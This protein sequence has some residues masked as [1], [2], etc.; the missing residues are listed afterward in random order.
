MQPTWFSALGF[1]VRS[2]RWLLCSLALVSFQ[3]Q[4]AEIIV[5]PGDNTLPGAIS[6]AAEGDT[7]L[8][9]EGTYF[10]FALTIDKSLNFKAQTNAS[11]IMTGKAGSSLFND[12]T[13][14]NALTEVDVSFTGIQLHALD[15][16]TLAGAEDVELII[17]EST[18]TG[19]DLIGDSSGNL[20][21]LVMMGN[22]IASPGFHDYTATDIVITGN[23]F[24]YP[25][26]G[27][28]YVRLNARDTAH[29]I[30]NEVTD[31]HARRTSLLW[32]N[33]GQNFVVANRFVDN[34]SAN[35]NN[36]LQDSHHT[37]LN[38]QGVSTRAIIK[39]NSFAVDFPSSF[40]PDP[41]DPIDNTQINRYRLLAVQSA[42]PRGVVLE[43]N[44]VDYG[45]DADDVRF[46]DES[47]VIFTNA[48]IIARN[49]IVANSSRPL[50]NL[51]TSEAEI[52]SILE[53]NLCDNGAAGG[54][55]DTDVIGSVNFVDNVNFAL[56]AGSAGINA[57][58]PLGL[59]N[60]VDGSQNDLGV[61]GGAFPI[62]Q[63]DVQRADGRIEPY[64][65]PLFE[66]NKNVSGDGKL[67]VRVIGLA[68]SK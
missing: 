60:D 63:Y 22:I 65:Y 38:I 58:N 6:L 7:L 21:L 13:I 33:S 3:S 50:I 25:T 53:Y 4:A 14:G 23:R 35:T 46:G 62:D 34:N 42:L 31:N 56:G 18:I 48:A 67:N 16:R 12:V 28:G 52:F 41:T 2:P 61:Y 30:G 40:E 32:L 45:M 54:V 44:T 15:I 47:P 43:N 68:R 39:N 36:A 37:L 27:T 57:G 10:L 11:P 26:D 66:P 24:L 59:F 51:E 9:K 64:L 5:P 20:E 49:N 8:L 29:F 17:V 19:T 55:C 1:I